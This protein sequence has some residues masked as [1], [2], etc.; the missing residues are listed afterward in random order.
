MTN[1]S[2]P[3]RRGQPIL[4]YRIVDAV[5]RRSLRML[6]L[7]AWVE[8][9]ALWWGYRFRPEP[10]VVLL[11]SGAKIHVDRVDHLQL[12]IYYLGVFEPHAVAILRRSVMPGATV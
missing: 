5:L 3:S 2:M 12:L 10:A 11:R 8:S 4:A 9:I 6:P 1:V 7:Q